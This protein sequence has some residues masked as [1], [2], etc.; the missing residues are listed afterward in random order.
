M[1]EQFPQNNET[2]TAPEIDY[3]SLEKSNERPEEQNE[4]RQESAAIDIEEAR[5]QAY[6][7]QPEVPALPLDDTADGDKPQYI[8]RAMRALSLRNELNQIRQRLPAS[9]RLLSKTIHQPIVRKA[10]DASAKTI[11]RPYGLL[12]GGIFAF[13]GSLAYLIFAK[14]IGIKYNYLIFILLFVAGYLLASIIEIFT[15]LFAKQ[16]AK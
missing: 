15:R 10:S 8:D 2:K 13:L 5:R 7:Q 16:Q 9:Q 12:G 14:Y 3:G 6:S 4:S 1:S 11:T